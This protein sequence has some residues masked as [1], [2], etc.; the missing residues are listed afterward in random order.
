MS[1]VTPESMQATVTPL[2][3][4]A[5]IRVAGRDR[6]KFLQSQLTNDIELLDATRVMS[7][8]WCDPK[9]RT[10]A[11][12][13]ICAF[14]DDILL[15][16]PREVAEAVLPKLRMYV[17]RLKVTL[18]VDDDLSLIGLHGAATV[19]ALT[20]PGIQTPPA[21]GCG[22]EHD[23]CKFLALRGDCRWLAIVDAARTEH[24]IAEAARNG[25]RVDE[26]DSWR[27]A[28]ILAGDPQIYAQ[29]SGEFVPQMVNLELLDGVSFS[30]GC[31]PGQ[32]IVARTQYLGKIKR[33]TFGFQLHT[34][35]TP[36][37]GTAVLN[38]DGTRIGQ[39]V[40]A[41]NDGSGYTHGL[42][43]LRVEA[44]RADDAQLQTMGLPLELVSLPYSLVPSPAS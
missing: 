18:V 13:Q 35:A 24:L 6:V 2:Q 4:L 10:L 37:P 31:Y 9:G 30:K 11:L 12:F 41:A 27:L 15:I 7:A 17:M 25:C 26:A 16:C 8:A 14:G 44:T 19:L 23:G 29:T 42:A 39:I 33:R 3:E 20:L 43:V 22:I 36:E 21:D 40:D 28:A 1:A 34:D 32:E 5:A 38:G